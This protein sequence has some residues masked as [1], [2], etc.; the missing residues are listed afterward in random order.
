ME[1]GTQVVVNALGKFTGKTATI[2]EIIGDLYIVAFS[3]GEQATMSKF[4]ITPKDSATDLEEDKDEWAGNDRIG[5]DELGIDDDVEEDVL[6]D[7][8]DE[9]VEDD[10]DLAP[11]ETHMWN[12]ELGAIMDEYFAEEELDKLD[13]SSLFWLHGVV[14]KALLAAYEAG[15]NSAAIEE[16]AERFDYGH[17]APKTKRVDMD[18]FDYVGRPETSGSRLRVVN[19]YADNPLMKEG[20]EKPRS[21][22]DMIQA[23]NNIK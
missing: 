7:P 11:E 16:D 19:N 3:D 8:D 5:A 15:K 4:E 10:T 20:S 2:E 9:L 22:R 12:A 17:D 1:K 14:Q 13:T 21:M 18:A 23:L 6:V